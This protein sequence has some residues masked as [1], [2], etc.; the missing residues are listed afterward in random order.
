MKKAHIV[1]VALFIVSILTACGS[2]PD[3][4]VDDALTVA[5]NVA[6][7]TPMPASFQTAQAA[8]NP[9]ATPEPQERVVDLGATMVYQ[10]MVIQMTQQVE[11]QERAAQSAAGTATQLSILATQE[12]GHQVATAQAQAAKDQATAQ[13]VNAD[14]TATAEALHVQSTATQAAVWVM[15]TADERTWQATQS[16]A[17]TQQAVIATQDYAVFE[18][19]ATAQSAE[20]ASVELKLKRERMTNGF[21][22]WSP[23]FILL[24]LVVA[25]LFFADRLSRIGRIEHDATGQMPAVMTLSNGLWRMV[26][27]D[28][29]ASPV[30]EIGPN[31]NAPMLADPDVQEATTRRAQAIEAM[32]HLPPSTANQTQSIAEAGFGTKTTRRAVEIIEECT[33]VLGAV[34]D[35]AEHELLGG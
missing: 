35:D 33:P 32:R 15:Q 3:I 30:V 20:A 8:L 21:I 19:R 10:N 13:S 11:E 23:F 2:Y 18:V 28:R 14:K 12:Y 1:L 7:G 22:A 27:P 17:Q 31:V 26:L 34:I 24:I 9:T 5:T 29:M 16:A 4:D 25:G 6:R